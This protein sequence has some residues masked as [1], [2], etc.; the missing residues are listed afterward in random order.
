MITLLSAVRS[1]RRTL[2]LWNWR[3]NTRNRPHAPLNAWGY[4]DV[5]YW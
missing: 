3:R 5:G 2:W 4:P 1:G